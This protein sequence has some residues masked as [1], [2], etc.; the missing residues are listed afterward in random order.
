VSGGT[1]S[2]PTTLDLQEEP[3]VHTQTRRSPVARILAALAALIVIPVTLA[4][5]T[6][7]AGAASSNTLTVKAG[8]YTYV[9]K[10]SPKAGWTQINF[11]NT[12][13]EDHMMAVFKLKKGTTASALKKAIASTDGSGFDAIA[14]TT[15]GDPTLAGTPG[16][17][18]PKQKT[19]TL[20][21]IPAGTYGIV[22][23]VAAPD[24]SPHAAHGMYK[25]FTVAGKSKFKPPTDGVADVSMTDTAITVPSGEAP[26]SV[27]LKVTNT[28]TKPHDLQ[29]VKLAAGKT[30][31]EAKAYFDQ[32]I[33]TGKAPEGDA[34]GALVGGVQGV[35]PNGGVSYVE[36]SLPAGTYGYVSTEGDAPNDDYTAGLHGTFTIK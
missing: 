7:S 3:L 26:R 4:V 17:L 11:E 35:A 33:N 12:G 22:C 8:E 16:V 15:N 24:G 34:P 18:G 1:I 2:G 9:L 5:S 27:T 25:I 23:F 13:V 19:T 21:K 32:L 30:L 10:G 6:S 14:D 36:W 20:T 31:D 29:L 28:G